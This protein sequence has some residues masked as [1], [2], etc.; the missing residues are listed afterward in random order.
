MRLIYTI[1]FVLCAA[2]FA[3]AQEYEQRMIDSLE[4]VLSKPLTKKQRLQNINY[5][6]YFYQDVNTE[7][8]ISLCEEALALIDS[9]TSKVDAGNTYLNMAL[10]TESKGEYVTSLAYNAKALQVFQALG[11][12]ISV[13]VIL[14]N[15]GIAYNQMGDYSMA[16]YY[17]LKAVEMDE[18]RRDTLYA[19]VDYINVAESYYSAK[20]FN[21]AVEWAR[22]A[23]QQLSRPAGEY[24]RGYAAEML[25]MAYIEVNKFDS[26]RHY[27]R[28]A[29][30]IGNKFSNEYL[31]NRSTG[32]LGRLYLKTKRYDSAEYYLTKTVQL[33]KGKNLSDILLPATIALSRCLLAKGN[34]G[35]AL[36]HATWAYQSSLEIKNKVLATE[37]CKLIASL[38]ESMGNKDENIRYLKLAAEYREEILQQSVQGSLQAKAFDIILEK[39]KRAKLI[40]EMSLSERGK[41]VIRQ[42]YLLAGGTVIVL[43]LLGMLYLLRKINIERKKTNEQLMLNNIQLDKLNEEINGLIHTI[44]HDLKSPLNSIPGI[45]YVLEAQVKDNAVVTE[46]M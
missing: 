24:N 46:M 28:I 35:D 45:L 38:Y 33:S 18:K 17:L 14:N 5:L 27:I 1:S 16:V 42:R 11:D 8:F 2:A 34:A 3:S 40:A 15:I 20:I 31:I 29:Q 7:R 4:Q 30:G 19:A 22:K 25:A 12:S 21:V 41:V 39:E 32:H 9:S 26:A 36:I 6:V 10:A 13:G 43:V 23:Y 37:S 44:V